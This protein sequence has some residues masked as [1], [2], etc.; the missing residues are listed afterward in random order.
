MHRNTEPAERRRLPIIIGF[1]TVSVNERLE[2]EQLKALANRSRTS[3]A[4][5]A[6]LYNITYESGLSF[7]L[8]LP[9][10]YITSI[11]HL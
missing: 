4:L 3:V 11:T 5:L 8:F 6:F 9:R 7:I 1:Q 10:P 2:R